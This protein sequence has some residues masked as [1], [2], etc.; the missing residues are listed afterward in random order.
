MS[1]EAMKLALE[2]IQDYVDEFGPNEKDSGAQYVINTLNKAIQEEALRNVQR[3][4]QEIE[5]EPVAYIRV[6]KTGNVMACAKTDDFYALPNGTLLYTHP[7]PKQDLGRAYTRQ[8]EYF[9]KEKF[10][11]L[12]VKECIKESMEEMVDEEEIVDEENPLIREYLMGNNQ[13]ITDAVV[14]LRNYFGI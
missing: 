6:S 9:D 7:Q 5:Q 1:T 4:G 3:I 13:G 12:I 2:I 8:E 14:R 10:A 11:K